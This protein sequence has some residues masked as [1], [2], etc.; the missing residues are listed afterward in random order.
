M[1]FKNNAQTAT[2]LLAVSLVVLSA[3]SAWAADGLPAAPEASMSAA[4]SAMSHAMSHGGGATEA[5]ASA[6]TTAPADLAAKTGT[7][8]ASVTGANVGESTGL[9]PEKVEGA[10]AKGNASF[11]GGASG[12]AEAVTEGARGAAGVSATGE[13][14]TKKLFDSL[15]NGAPQ[16][17]AGTEAGAGISPT[18]PAAKTP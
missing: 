16:T 11:S 7:T 6:G 4:P 14:N 1:K 2:R 8:G 3:G 12:A 18:A 10:T 17:Q 13:S 15:N 9:K 5:G